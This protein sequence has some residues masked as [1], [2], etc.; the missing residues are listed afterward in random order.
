MRNLVLLSMLFLSVS[1]CWA[2]YAREFMEIG[3]SAR[4]VA[5]G[6]GGVS[7]CKG[8][9]AVVWNP[10][11]L[12]IEPTKTVG[13][14]HMSFLG[15]ESYDFISAAYSLPNYGSVGIGW[16]RLGVGDIPIYP[17]LPGSHEERLVNPHMRSEFTPTGYL[18]D[19]ETAFIL[20]YSLV[21]AR[22]LRYYR[23]RNIISIGASIKIFN[24]RIGWMRGKGIGWDLGMA[25]LFP[26]VGGWRVKVGGM[27]ADV[28]MSAMRWNNGT[29][30]LIPADFRI[31]IA[32]E[33]RINEWMG[34]NLVGAVKT[35]YSLLFSLGTE[36]SLRDL[37]FLRAGIKRGEPSFGTGFKVKG[38][39]IDY[40]L[41]I[42]DLSKS[43]LVSVRM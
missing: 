16:M 15:L 10:A 35:R 23:E 36:I 11:I 5:L 20:S 41:S 13:M 2:N 8:S 29:S 19:V 33:R 3:P 42:G 9:F 26:N 14:S 37:L 27:I 6:G 22:Y 12:A 30:D 18:M 34:L 40:T 7:T 38:V 25:V 24:Q 43:H 4:E 17:E 28:F 21:P 31:G 1:N 32:G 39:S